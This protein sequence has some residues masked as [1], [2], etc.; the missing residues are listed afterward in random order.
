LDRFVEITVEY[1]PDFAAEKEKAL[2]PVPT[3]KKE[4]KT[5]KQETISKFYNESK[6]FERM[7]EGTIDPAT[8][9]KIGG[10]KFVFDEIREKIRYFH[11]AFHSTTPE[12]LNSRLTFLLQC[13]RQGPTLEQQGATNLA[14]GRPPICI[15]RIGDFYYTKIIMENVNIDY[16]PLVWDL[17][18]EGIG[19][20]PMIANVDISFKFLGGSSLMGPI[21]KLQNAL[22][23]NYFANTHVYDPRADYIA[24]KAGI[25]VG[26]LAENDA[27]ISTL[28]TN[29]NDIKATDASGFRIFNGVAKYEPELGKLLSQI[30]DEN[31]KEVDQ[32]K[33]EEKV[34][35]GIENSVQPTPPPPAGNVENDM[36]VI[37]GFNFKY[38][39]IDETETEDLDIKFEFVFQ[40]KQNTIVSLTKN[41]YGKLYIQNTKT[42]E[43]KLI[44]KITLSPNGPNTVKFDL[45]SSG[46]EPVVDLDNGKIKFIFSS[47][48]VIQGDEP[49]VSFI[50]T[51]YAGNDSIIKIEWE[52]G[53][54]SGLG[55][56]VNWNKTAAEY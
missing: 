30:S 12:G 51:A 29:S 55:P 39:K 11:P 18:P 38:S 2:Q 16:E 9:E 26:A 36:N 47:E 25:S 41:Y 6:Y 4:P 19:V 40:P 54:G 24:K 27:S 43:K 20:Q 32:V 15:L 21:N 52:T 5:V 23:F 31:N 45:K 44:D 35:G 50:K 56:Q 53:S 28:E 3:V 37:F 1:D 17:N 34:N 10:N 42:K 13:T 14:F 33:A 49:L 46:G 48:T 7:V 8:G 22:S